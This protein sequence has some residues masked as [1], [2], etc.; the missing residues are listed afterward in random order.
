MVKPDAQIYETSSYIR[1]YDI[2]GIV[3][4]YDR[5]SRVAAIEQRNKVYDGDKVEILSTRGDNFYIY[6][7][8]M[9]NDSG[10]K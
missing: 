3:K 7:N 5:K 10:Q 9:K 6:L 2:V 4:E 1:D 8:D